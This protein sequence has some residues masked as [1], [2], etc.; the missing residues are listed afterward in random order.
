MK[1][2][3]TGQQ[4]GRLTVIRKDGKLGQQTAWLCRCEC[5]NAVRLRTNALRSGNTRSCGCYAKE[6][7]SMPK[8]Y[9][10]GI[11]IDKLYK[12]W[13][14]MIDRCTNSNNKS[15]SRYGG[16]GISV[17][18]EWNDYNA[19]AEWAIQNGYSEKLSLDRINNDGNYE[20]NNCRWTTM[21]VQRNN[22]SSNR[23]ETINGIT[24]TISEWADE[25]GV[26]YSTVLQRLNAGMNITEALTKEMKY[27]GYGIPIRCVDTGEVF[28]SSKEASEK[29]GV[30]LGAIA[31]AARLGKTSCGMRWE[32]IYDEIPNRS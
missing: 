9:R 32:Q 12:A 3:L 13:H 1:L 14:A 10:N 20:P 17:C 15:F 27:R 21:K 5:G 25:Y 7:Q 18:N 31:K 2:D 30:S 24:K 22:T 8:K 26:R 29:Y 23:Y 16:R 11:F 6:Y 4:F 28:K 19:F